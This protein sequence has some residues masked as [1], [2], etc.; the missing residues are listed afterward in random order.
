MFP[1]FLCD[2]AIYLSSNLM[3]YCFCTVGHRFYCWLG[4]LCP[5]SHAISVMK[6]VVYV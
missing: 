5:D 1:A 3:V 6:I 2:G 4:D